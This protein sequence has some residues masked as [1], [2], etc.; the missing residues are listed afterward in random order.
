MKKVMLFGALVALFASSNLYAATCDNLDTPGDDY[1]DTCD[2]EL[3]LEIPKLAVIQF[4]PPGGNDGSDLNVVWDGTA[5]GPLTDSINICIGTNGDA[6]VSLTTTSAN[7][8]AFN[9]K[10]GTTNI[11][12]T[13]TLDGNDLTTGPVD[14]ADADTDNLTCANTTLPL[15]LGFALADLQTADTDGTAFTDTVTMVVEPK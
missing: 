9:V 12:Y 14:V 7:T 6:G 1:N 5:T 15:A 11:A 10:Q 13:L 4:P 3:Q 2:V 8:T